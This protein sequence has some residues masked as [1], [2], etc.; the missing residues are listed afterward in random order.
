M[1]PITVGLIGSNGIVG[2]NFLPYLATAHKEGKIK[3][4]VLH[5]EGSDLSKVPEGVEKRVLDLDGGKADKSVVGDLEVVISAISGKAIKSQIPLIDLL[6]GSKVLKTF[7][8]SDFGTTWTDEELKIPALSSIKEKEEVV[9]H[10]KKQNVPLT[11]IRNGLFDLFFFT[12]KG[13]GT[14]VKA[15]KV[16]EF[17]NSLKNPVHITTLSYLSYA[18]TQLVSTPSHLSSL[19]GSTVLLV[20]YTPTGQDFVSVLTKLHGK[21]TEITQFTEEE[22]KEGLKGDF[23]IPTAIAGKW[24]DNNWG[25]EKIFEGIEGWKKPSLEELVKQH[26]DA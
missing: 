3:L 7:I 10:A 17:R 12:Y 15:N 14:D 4:T 5:R 21:P 6:A 2:S 19:P 22:Y 8:H 11:T 25:D 18:V 9:A 1:S 23:A 26:I 20:D 24:G 13:L 16:R